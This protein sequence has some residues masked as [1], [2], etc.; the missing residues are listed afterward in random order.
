[1]DQTVNEPPHYNSGEIECIE[2]LEDNLSEE[3]Y[4]GYLEG[5][6]KKYLHRYRYK[7]KAVEDLKKAIWY[8]DRL[9][10]VYEKKEQ[11]KNLKDLMTQPSLFD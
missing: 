5:N 1:M 7:G 6:V 8:L 3:G 2:Y 10:Q 11:R 9:T 4:C